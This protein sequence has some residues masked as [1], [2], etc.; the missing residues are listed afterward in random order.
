M[1]DV[2]IG[3]LS[4]IDQN[5]YKKIYV[6]SVYDDRVTANLDEI[7]KRKKFNMEEL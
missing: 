1:I 2:S 4:K 5:E 6:S 7:I 3:G